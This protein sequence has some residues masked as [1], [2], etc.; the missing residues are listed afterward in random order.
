IRRSGSGNPGGV[1]AMRVVGRRWGV[2]VIVLD[3]AKGALAGLVGMAIAGDAGA[4]T[5]AAAALARHCFPVWTRCAGGMGAAAAR[6]RV[7][8]VRGGGGAGV[9]LERLSTQMFLI[10]G[11]VAAG[12]SYVT[13]QRERAIWIAADAWV[14]GAVV[15][16]AADL[17][18]LWGPDPGVGLVLYSV[19]GA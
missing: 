1:N 9:G 14:G 10:G 16:A 2:L 8:G 18:T 15:C 13:K 11:A 5:A 7:W 6:R 12:A 3:A 19:L 17:D 4:H